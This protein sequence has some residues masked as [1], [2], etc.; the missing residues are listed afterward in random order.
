M[1]IDSFKTDFAER[2]PV[3]GIQYHDGADL[4]RMHNYYA[5][6]YNRIVFETLSRHLGPD[7][8]LLFARSTA[9]GG[10][11][12]PVHWGGNCESTFEAMAASLHDD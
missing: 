11:R 12:Y 6:L 9:P 8:G 4:D 10:Q 1:G 5:L 3:K 7:Q 2:I